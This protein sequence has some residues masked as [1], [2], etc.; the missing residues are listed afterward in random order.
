MHSKVKRK[1][2]TLVFV[3]LQVRGLGM[4][5]GWWKGGWVQKEKKIH[6]IVYHKAT[7]E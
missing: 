1:H 4:G 3:C 5:V 7:V 6:L 2:L